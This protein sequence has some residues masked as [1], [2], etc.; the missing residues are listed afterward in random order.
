MRQVVVYLFS[1]LGLASSA[2]A[3]TQCVLTA[4]PAQMRVGGLADPLGSIILACGGATPFTPLRGS[5]QIAVSTVVANRL[6]DGQ[7]PE[8]QFSVGAGSGWTPLTSV[9]AR[10]VSFNSVSIENI[11]TLFDANGALSMRFSGLRAE[12][13]TQVHAVLSFSGTPQLPVQFSLVTVG[14]ESLTLAS[15]GTTTTQYASAALPE[16]FD[17]NT[18]LSMR[19]PFLTTRVTEANAAAFAP[20]PA[21]AANGVRILVKFTGIVTQAALYIP[22]AI[23]GSTAKTP[24]AAGDMGVAVSP[25]E[26]ESG[27]TL[28][29]ARVRGSDA[30]GSGGELAFTP[31][32]GLNVLGSLGNAEYDPVE[33]IRYAVY[34]VVDAAEGVRETVQ[35][36]AFVVLPP[37]YRAGGPL[38]RQTVSLAPIS[39]ERGVSSTAPVPRF[40]PAAVQNDCPLLDD[41]AASYFP[42]ITAYAE[43]PLAFWAPAGSHHQIGY[44]LVSNAGGGILEWHVSVRYRSGSDW[45]RFFPSEGIQRASVRF[46]VLPADLTPGTYQADLVLT[47]QANAGE[48][49]FPITLVVTAPPPPELPVP[50]VNG[51]FNAANRIPGPLAPSSLAVVLGSQFSE[52]AKATVAGVP[53]QVLSAAADALVIEIPATLP[54]APQSSVVVDVDSRLSA[55]YQFDL[56]PVAPAV[57]RGVNPDGTPNTESAPVTA[58]TV[59]AL[60][61]TGIRQAESPVWLRLHDREIAEFVP[62]PL[63]A[64]NPAGI[65]VIRFVIPAD[66]PT[67]RTALTICGAPAGQPDLRRCS[68]PFDVYL[69]AAAE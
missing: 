63:D 35:F 24:T 20:K 68:H 66:L 57:A 39:S 41:C 58:G 44:I 34:E 65:D 10:P 9:T 54:D 26:Y 59:L 52:T 8:I 69:R 15:S 62:A 55:P 60:D 40:L 1:I 67:M 48:I 7:L 32:T 11:D 61:V 49:Q 27:S 16:G 14:G 6:I 22:D 36:P 18:L 38:V 45:V 53:A 19:V 37:E 13:D 12:T 28:L 33:D 64:V 47:G 17:F 30:T 50:V 4:T 5:F 42:R 43:S 21:G 3:F 56:V 29:L 2:Q 46:D 51:I 25:G 23:A 31:T